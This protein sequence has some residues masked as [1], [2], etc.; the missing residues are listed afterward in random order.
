VNNFNRA[1]GR[2]M[3]G[4][5]NWFYALYRARRAMGKPLNN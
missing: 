5:T 1:G 4:K 2:P 3:P